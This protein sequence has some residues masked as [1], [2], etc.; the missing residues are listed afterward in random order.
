M[1][2][3]AAAPV[4]VV[5]GMP[6]KDCCYGEQVQ[7]QA[8]PPPPPIPTPTTPLGAPTPV[9]EPVAVTTPVAIADPAAAPPKKMGNQLAKAG[10]KFPDYSAAK[11][12]GFDTDHGN[13]IGKILIFEQ[14]TGQVS[15][16]SNVNWYTTRTS[17]TMGDGN[18]MN[19]GCASE[20]QPPFMQLPRYTTRTSPTMGDGNCM[21]GGCASELDFSE[22]NNC[23]LQLTIHICSSDG[24]GDIKEFLGK[25]TDPAK[26]EGQGGRLTRG[27]GGMCD[28]W[29]CFTRAQNEYAMDWYEEG[30]EEPADEKQDLWGP[31]QYIDAMQWHEIAWYFVDEGGDIGEILVRMKQGKKAAVVP[32]CTDEIMRMD[33]G[34][35]PTPDG[36]SKQYL[37]MLSKHVKAPG[38]RVQH[39]KWGEELDMSWLA[40]YRDGNINPHCGPGPQKYPGSQHGG[41]GEHFKNIRTFTVPES[42]RPPQAPVKAP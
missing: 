34:C 13:L 1:S 6:K 24:N 41:E 42:A 20:L 30:A 28:G 23:G 36:W 31:G 15:K 40:R 7:L 8:A 10:F 14:N 33:A 29:G 32:V 17:P 19:G 12:N 37:K 18:C 5:V 16:S 11:P 25:G 9:V 35:K 3:P 2:P 26:L 38:W 39:T 22:G 21:N 27:P 4:P